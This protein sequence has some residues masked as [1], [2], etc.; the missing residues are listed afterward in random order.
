MYDLDLYAQHRSSEDDSESTDELTHELRSLSLQEIEEVNDDVAFF[1]TPEGHPGSGFP[2]S[3]WDDDDYPSAYEEI[4]D[5][6]KLELSTVSELLGLCCASLVHLTMHFVIRIHGRPGMSLP[7]LFPH[8]RDLVTNVDIEFFTH[9]LENVHAHVQDPSQQPPT[10]LFPCL[11]NLALRVGTL[12]DFQYQLLAYYPPQAP[13]LSQLHLS[14]RDAP[15][16]CPSAVLELLP[17]NV[18]KCNLE[19]N[20]LS[21]E[22]FSRRRKKDDDGDDTSRTGKEKDKVDGGADG[23]QRENENLEGGEGWEVEESPVIDGWNRLGKVRSDV[24]TDWNNAEAL[25]QMWIDWITG[26]HRPNGDIKKEIIP[27]HWDYRSF[28]IS[29]D[30]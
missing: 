25:M 13:A 24:A 17:V 4:I 27:T 30:E 28:D 9:S 7:Y 20:I 26:R 1:Q 21:R 29:D 18:R 14:F 19:L 22:S 2:T 5:A 15:M 6:E 10:P 11:E 8:L 12:Q 16:A 3:M 23:T